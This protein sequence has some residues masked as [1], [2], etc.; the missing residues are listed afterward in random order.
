MVFNR[1][2]LFMKTNLKTDCTE[3]IIVLYCPELKGNINRLRGWGVGMIALQP[4]A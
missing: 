2:I 3:S 4:V 1:S